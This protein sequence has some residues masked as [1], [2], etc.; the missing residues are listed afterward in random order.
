MIS[1]AQESEPRIILRETA[2]I[3]TVCFKE[4]VEPG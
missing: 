1:R 4:R 2:Q 3:I